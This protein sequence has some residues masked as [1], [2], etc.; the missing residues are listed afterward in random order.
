MIKGE[1]VG[2][3]MP[4]SIRWKCRQVSAQ[5]SDL[6]AQASGLCQSLTQNKSFM[7]YTFVWLNH[8]LKRGHNNFTHF[9]TLTI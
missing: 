5:V 7:E 6:N 8:D 1:G 3:P 2:V 9:N 4:K